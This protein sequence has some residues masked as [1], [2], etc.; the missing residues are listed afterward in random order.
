[1]RIVIA[2]VETPEAAA[3][4]TPASIIAAVR[5]AAVPEDE[6]AHVYADLLP[7]G[8][9]VVVYLLVP[10]ARAAATG[11]RLIL[12]AAD[13]LELADWTLGEVKVWDPAPFS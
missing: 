6:L 2:T 7:A 3:W 12:A 8:F 9:G 1:M 4:T 13:S 11:S 5:A 10:R